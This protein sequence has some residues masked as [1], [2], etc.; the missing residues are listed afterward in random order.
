MSNVIRYVAGLGVAVLALLSAPTDAAIVLYSQNFENPVGFVN[1]GGDINIFRPVNQLYGN[2]P[3]GFAFAQAN[4]VE[5]LLLTGNQAFGTGYS[6]PQ[7]IGGNYALGMLS[8]FSSENDLLGLS[9]NVQGQN[10]LNFRVNISSVDLDRFG[11]PCNSATGSVASFDVLLFDN[12]TGST[13]LS[14]N[15]TVLDSERITALPSSARN[16]LTWSEHILALDASGSANGS[17]TLRIDLVASAANSRYAA[18]DNF[19]IVASDTPGD[20]GSVPE[21][22][23]ITL[24]GLG[25]AGLLLFRR[26]GNLRP[27]NDR[28]RTAVRV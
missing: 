22:A 21:P 15:G 16:V 20:V 6:D 28:A 25:L 8:G 7:G 23:S 12:P 3:P 18:M 27:G 4:T 13:S 5:T 9:F 14:G 1:D 17:V 19:R 11:C 26:A 10:F 2:Q 24:F